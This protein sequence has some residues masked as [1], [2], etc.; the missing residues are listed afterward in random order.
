MGRRDLVRLWEALTGRE[1]GC[2]LPALKISHGG[3]AWGTPHPPSLN[4][5]VQKGGGTVSKCQSAA[6]SL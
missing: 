4:T 1:L 6:L 5:L 3:S 2:N